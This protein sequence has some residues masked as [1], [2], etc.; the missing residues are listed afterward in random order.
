MKKLNI[1][2]E[3]ILAKT[4]KFWKKVQ[5]IALS[6]GVSAVAVLLSNSQFVLD[7][8]IE[9]LTYIKYTVAVCAAIAGTAQL[10]KEDKPNEN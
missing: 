3:R 10:T 7:L 1:L 9:L 6:I 4:P 2:V 8:P 5:A